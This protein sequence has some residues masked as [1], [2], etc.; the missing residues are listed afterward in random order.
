MEL[1]T[2]WVAHYGYAAIFSLLVLGIVGLPVPDEWL[3]A[4][5]GYMVFKDHLLLVPALA[6]AWL[7]SVCGITISYGIGRS[8]GLYALHH[9]GRFFRIT[10]EGVEKTRASYDRYGM[11]VLFFGYFIPGVRHFTAIVAGTLRIRFRHFSLFAYSG[12]LIWSSVF[13]GIGYL[14]GD[15]WTEVLKQIHRHL[16][17]VAWMA[18]ILIFVWMGRYFR[19]STVRNRY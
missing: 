4:L 18:L 10:P 8:M 15:H 19:K 9:Y 1:I 16:V 12:A 2:Q 17:I 14:F 7:G 5:A 3:L 6:C 13:I 11:W